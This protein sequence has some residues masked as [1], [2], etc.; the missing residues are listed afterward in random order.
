MRAVNSQY[1]NILLEN[2]KVK[3]DLYEAKQDIFNM[4]QQEMNGQFN[5]E[6]YT[7]EISH[8]QM[9]LERSEKNFAVKLLVSTS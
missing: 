2:E 5:I 1:Q 9:Q 3:R 8:L 7:Q 6:K 4:K